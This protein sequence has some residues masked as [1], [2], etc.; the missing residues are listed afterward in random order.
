[1]NDKVNIISEDGACATIVKEDRSFVLNIYSSNP[2]LWYI[3]LF[4]KFSFFNII[5]VQVK[6]A[7]ISHY[8]WIFKVLIKYY[9]LLRNP[10]SM[11]LDVWKLFLLIFLV[12][13]Y[14]I[15]LLT[16][17]NAFALKSKFDRYLVAP[18]YS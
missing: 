8:Y 15:S 7:K 10:V 9:K 14:E 2:W 4:I 1:M 16:S 13:C 6:C 11:L 3:F 12:D 17:N 18:D 5:R